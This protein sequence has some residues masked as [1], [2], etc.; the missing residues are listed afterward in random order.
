MLGTSGYGM[1]GTSGYGMLG[2]VAYLAAELLL[3]LL[4]CFRRHLLELVSFEAFSS[5]VGES[6]GRSP[7]GIGVLLDGLRPLPSLFRPLPRRPRVGALPHGVLTRIS[8]WGGQGR[9]QRS[10]LG[11][12]VIVRNDQLRSRHIFVELRGNHVP[13]CKLFANKKK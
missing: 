12:I 9:A 10:K 4:R 6:R 1:L 13:E 7:D 5:A 11:S 8:G 2:P 3:G